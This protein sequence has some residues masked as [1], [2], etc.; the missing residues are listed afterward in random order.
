MIEQ[1]LE[2]REQRVLLLS[3]LVTA[4]YADSSDLDICQGMPE[5]D[6]VV[7]GWLRLAEL[8]RILLEETTR[9]VQ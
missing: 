1:D 2:L 5:R 9:E 8:L 4:L 3:A 6:S 7:S